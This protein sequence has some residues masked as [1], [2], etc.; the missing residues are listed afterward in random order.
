MGLER[1][2]ELLGAKQPFNDD[3]TLTDEGT[4][5]MEKVIEFVTNLE[6]IDAVGKSGDELMCYLDEI[7]RLGF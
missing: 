7:V 1:M 4:E 5:A 3:G 2:L 6:Y